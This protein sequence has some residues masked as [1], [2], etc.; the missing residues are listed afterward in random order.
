[1]KPLTYEE[2][3]QL[4]KAETTQAQVFAETVEVNIARKLEQELTKTEIAEMAKQIESALVIQQKPETQQ[5]S[6]QTIQIHKQKADVTSPIV[7]KI[8][9]STETSTQFEVSELKSMTEETPQMRRVVSAAERHEHKFAKETKVSLETEVLEQPQLTDIAK[10]SEQKVVVQ[11]AHT[12]MQKPEE[13]FPKLSKAVPL[14]EVTEAATI[15]LLK[16]EVKE[17]PIPQQVETD[18]LKAQKKLATETKA[19]VQLELVEESTITTVPEKLEQKVTTFDIKQVTEK[20]EKVSPSLTKA[21]TLEEFTTQ[22]TT[23]V[24]KEQVE[25]LETTLD[26]QQ[27]DAKYTPLASNLS[28]ALPVE[29]HID[30]HEICKVSGEVELKMEERV[31]SPIETQLTTIPVAE[32]TAWSM[33]EKLEQPKLADIKLPTTESVALT[34]VPFESFKAKCEDVPQVLE[35]LADKIV[36]EAITETVEEKKL[37][38]FET[39]LKNISVLENNILHLEVF[40]SGTTLPIKWFMENVELGPSPGVIIR[41]DG[42]HSEYIIE[43]CYPEDEGL[44]TAVATNECGKVTTSAYITILRKY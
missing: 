18:V 1:M 19:A 37:P 28:Q 6:S 3:R 25:S 16:E 39:G 22:T 11:K 23:M 40:A 5:I 38:K 26:V 14:Q 34:S 27:L 8:I 32:T 10:K 4:V 24:L 41:Q 31:V 30:T 15:M 33:E 35:V 44:Y 7:A 9:P 21:V 17:K 12:K 42:G 29:E 43:E 13:K 36:S 20:P 2:V